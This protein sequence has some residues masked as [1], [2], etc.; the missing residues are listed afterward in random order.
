[1]SSTVVLTIS[2]CHLVGVGGLV[3][4]LAHM[5]H[6]SDHSELSTSAAAFTLLG[7]ATLVVTLFVMFFAG[8][9]IPVVLLA[10]LTLLAIAVNI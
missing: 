6:N 5:L 3:S 1:M 9:I 4:A 8:S 10:V 2:L 7:L